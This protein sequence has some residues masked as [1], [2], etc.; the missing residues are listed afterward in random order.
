MD[1]LGIVT[2]AVISSAVAIWEA[3]KQ[4]SIPIIVAL[5]LFVFLVILGLYALI[6]HLFAPSTKHIKD[7]SAVP[8]NFASAAAIGTSPTA[9]ASHILALGMVNGSVREFVAKMLVANPLV[10]AEQADLV[11]NDPAHEFGQRIG[12]NV[13][14]H[15]G[16]YVSLATNSADNRSFAGTDTNRAT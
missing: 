4:P 5:W 3:L 6:R 1:R 13:L 8:D 16:D 11:R 7:V 14:N 9:H 10:G 15:E 2:G 12:A